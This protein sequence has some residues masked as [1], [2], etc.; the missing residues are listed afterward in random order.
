[1]FFNCDSKT[2]FLLYK[3]FYCDRSVESHYWIRSKALRIP[4]VAIQK[5]HKEWWHLDD[6]ELDIR[7][8]RSAIV[9]NLIQYWCRKLRSVLL[10][11]GERIS[12]KSVLI[13]YGVRRLRKDLG[14]LWRIGEGTSESKWEL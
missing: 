8:A 1:M 7:Q 2:T 13:M 12:S 11:Q 9:G 3:C 14:C 10:E 6:P 5:A 4:Q